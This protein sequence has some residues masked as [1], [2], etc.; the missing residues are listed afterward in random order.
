MFGILVY[1]Y[2]TSKKKKKRAMPELEFGDR[3][4]LSFS[5]VK[6]QAHEF[7]I[8]GQN[9]LLKLNFIFK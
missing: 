1:R 2:F 6:D 4:F 7:I 3:S 5:T 8:I 9:K